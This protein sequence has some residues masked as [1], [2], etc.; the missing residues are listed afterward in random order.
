VKE[1]LETRSLERSSGTNE[2]QLTK[3]LNWSSFTLTPLWNAE[4]DE[5][6]PW[7][8]DVTMH[9]FRSGVTNASIAL[10]NYSESKKGTRHGRPVGFPTFK[11]RHS[12]QSVTF[13]ETKTQ[14]G[15]FAEDSRHVRLILPRYAADPRI[16]RR[17]EQLR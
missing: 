12:K 14:V 2:A 9:A 3:S 16:T 11:N 13:I 10:K 4:R 6:A 8:R 1:N 15:W 5:V 17:R 7:H